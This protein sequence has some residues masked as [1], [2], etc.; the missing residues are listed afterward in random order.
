MSARQAV[1][2]G[3]R[4]LLLTLAASSLARADE[5][6]KATEVASRA[7][8]AAAAG[9]WADAQNSL[10]DELARCEAE[11][12][13]RACRSLVQFNLGFLYERWSKTESDQREA[14]LRR[15][16][17]AYRAV[18]ADSPGHEAT[19]R[20]LSLALADL[21]DIEGLRALLEAEGKTSPPEASRIAVLIGDLQRAAGRPA[22]A[23]ATYRQAAA[24]APNDETPCRRMAEVYAS[25]PGIDAAAFLRSLQSWQE[26]FPSVAEQG[27]AAL[28]AR[29]D[30]RPEIGEQALLGWV[31]VTSSERTISAGL[32]RANLPAVGSLPVRQLG[33][34]LDLLEMSEAPRIATREDIE[35]AVHPQPGDDDRFSWWL[36]G[37]P[38][39]NA[40]A[41]AALAKGRAAIV[42]QQ[43][44]RAQSDWL[45]GLRV[46]PQ[47][48]DYLGGQG[49]GQP[50][51]YLDLLTELA[52]A[53]FRFQTQLDPSGK[54]FEAFVDL[55]IES[56]GEAYHAHDLVA[57][58]RHHTIL[59][60]LLAAKGIWK[61]WRYD[62][63]NA[64]FQ[65]SNAVRVSQLRTEQGSAY[66]P[67]AGIKALLAE[68]YVETGRKEDA[69][70][71]YIAAAAA[72]LDEDDLANAQA[73]LKQ[74]KAVAPALAGGQAF[75]SLQQVA[76]DRM[77]IQSLMEGTGT[78]LGTE[79]GWL[80]SGT[81]PGLPSDFMQRQGFKTAADL[82]SLAALRKDDAA[83]GQRAQAALAL[84]NKLPS[85][86]GT[87]D[88]TR[89]Q[90]ATSLLHPAGEGA[91]VVLTADPS[92]LPSTTKRWKLTVPSSSLSNYA[93]FQE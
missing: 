52:W 75:L 72:Y 18:L 11:A 60:Q 22:D 91:G 42:A 33:D 87:A 49:Q 80:K 59:G 14:L 44:E 40:L 43:P 29:P 58:Q 57:I 12:P 65:L 62:F 26:R 86:I 36:S 47:V 76:R 35:R 83:A 71:T 38:R 93:V 92:A 90:S 78:S 51:A 68:G 61:P 77:A 74:T 28:L 50:Y 53:Q 4:V 31:A 54:K 73:M 82:A 10:A 88:L 25:Q 19:I 32:L 15:S 45:I 1:V 30:V 79:P 63:D 20:N 48:F 2:A 3:A 8:A 46:G 81:L 24:Y 64:V 21:G 27:Y 41:L 39:R 67:M 69:G 70:K 34:Y 16:V 66:E 89:L 85:L 5:Y 55:L 56:K 17:A 13:G 6:A 9:R 84:A 37:F 23:L 7:Q